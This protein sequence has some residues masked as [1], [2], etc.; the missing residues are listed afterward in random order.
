M[1][2]AGFFRERPSV[3]D[4]LSPFPFARTERERERKVDG[5]PPLRGCAAPFDGSMILLRHYP[6]GA[7]GE[8]ERERESEGGDGGREIER[9]KPRI[10]PLIVCIISPI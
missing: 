8:R 7:L 4:L 5:L 10:A 3:V 6:R 9:T 2:A 1:L